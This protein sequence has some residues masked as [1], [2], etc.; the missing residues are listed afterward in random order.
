MGIYSCYIVLK[1]DD[2]FES[3]RKYKKLGQDIKN[4]KT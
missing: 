2:E 4:K 3:R 1:L